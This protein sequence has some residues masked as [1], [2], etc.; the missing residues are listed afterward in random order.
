TT[1]TVTVTGR[2]LTG[3][4]GSA[5]WSFTTVVGEG[6]ISGTVRDLEGGV[7]ANAMVSLNNGA[8]T[9]TDAHGHF[10]FVD[11]PPGKY[12]LTITKEGYQTMT[13]EVV[14]T[15]DQ[16]GDLGTLSA[17]ATVPAADNSLLIITVLVIT[18]VAGLGAILLLGRRQSR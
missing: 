9:S 5:T 7:M 14:V 1:Y 8:S 4:A 3:T 17:R 2:T 6:N 16:T 10:S 11:L 18:S 15:P 13:R 12:I